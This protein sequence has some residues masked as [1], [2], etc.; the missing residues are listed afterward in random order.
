MIYKSPMVENK[1]TAEFFARMFR[2]CGPMMTPEMINPMIPGMFNRFNKMG[3]SNMINRINEKIKTGFF[4][5][6]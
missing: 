3:D 4:N 1:S 5:G 6:S 2:P